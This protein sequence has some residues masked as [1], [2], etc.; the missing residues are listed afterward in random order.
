MFFVVNQ[1]VGAALAAIRPPIPAKAA[2]TKAS[3]YNNQELFQKRMI[4]GQLMGYPHRQLMLHIRLVFL[5]DRQG[6][7]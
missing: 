1:H 4:L 5:V 2:P 7:Y 3:K 6:L